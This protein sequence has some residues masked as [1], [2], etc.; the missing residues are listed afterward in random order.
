MIQQQQ[1]P[2]DKAAEFGTSSILQDEL[3]KKV[4]KTSAIDARVEREQLTKE[5][6]EEQKRV[7]ESKEPTSPR[8]KAALLRSNTGITAHPSETA[9][10]DSSNTRAAADGKKKH[11]ESKYKKKGVK[12][13]QVGSVDCFGGST[14][15]CY[16]Q[17]F[18]E[19]TCFV[20][21]IATHHRN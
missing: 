10:E 14:L 15:V 20:T 8:D 13:F 1:S 18:K 4:D 2:A 19:P 9:P 17:S 6:M 11:K 16:F 5:W 21:Y 12:A 3:A 7:K